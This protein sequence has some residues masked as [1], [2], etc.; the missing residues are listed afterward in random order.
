MVSSWLAEKDRLGL[1]TIWMQLGVINED[2]A[3]LAREA[4]LTVVMDRCPKIEY[5]RMSGEISW[6]GVNRK[7]ID[8]RKPLLFGKGGS[9]KRI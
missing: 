5:G 8:N 6:M 3:A 4:G 2:A 7:V 1:K 9:L